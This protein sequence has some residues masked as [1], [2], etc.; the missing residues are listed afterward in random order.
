MYAARSSRPFGLLQLNQ[1]TV[2]TIVETRINEPKETPVPAIPY[3]VAGCE[4]G[5]EAHETGKI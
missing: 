5:G 3:S 1:A 4:W 2:S